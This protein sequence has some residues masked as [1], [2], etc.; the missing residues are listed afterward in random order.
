MHVL[1]SLSI[2]SA[3]QQKTKCTQEQCESSKMNFNNS[4]LTK[5]KIDKVEVKPLPAKL[6]SCAWCG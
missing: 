4:A 6:S 2:T 1:V 5:Q 3:Q